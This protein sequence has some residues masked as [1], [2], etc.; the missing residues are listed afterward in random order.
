MITWE[1]GEDRILTLTLDDRTQQTNT[2]NERFAADLGATV[3]R[4]EAEKDSFDGVILTSAKESFVAGGDLVLLMESGPEDVKKIADGLDHYKDCFRRIER[5]GRPV[6]AAVNGTALGGGFE[7]ALAAH[8]RI[9]LD[10]P[11]TL[12]GLPEVT[13]GVLPGAGGVTRVVRMIGVVNAMLQVIGQGQRMKPQ[14]AL[15]VGIVDEVVSTSEEMFAHARAWIQANPDASQPW[16]KPGYRI[17]GGSA[18]SSALAANL[19][20]FPANLRKQLKGAPMPA[21]AAVLATAVEGAAVDVDSAFRI[22]TRYCAN[23]ICGPVSGNMIKALFFDMNKVNKGTSR[24][25]GYPERRPEK[26]AVLGAGMMGAAIAYVTARAGV[27]VVLKDVSLE[28]AERGKDYSRRLLD[29]AVAKGRLSEQLREEVLGRIVATDNVAELKGSDFVVEAVFEDLE[30]KKSVLAEVE[31]YLS[32]DALIAT[33]TSALPL[34]EMAAAV[35]RPEDFIGLHFFSPVDKMPLLEVVVA[36]GTSAES[37]ARAFDFARII[38]KTPIVVRDAYAFYANRVI[39]QFVDQALSMLGEGVHPASIEQATTQAGF[40]VGALALL[41]EVNMRTTIKI[42]E[43]MMADQGES[44]VTTP[45][46]SIQRR[47]VEE[48]DRPGRA[49]GR[50]FYDYA[51]DGARLGLWPQLVDEYHRSEVVIP[52]DDL[53]ERLLVAASLEAARCLESGIIGT[54]EE[55]NVGSILGIGFPAWTGGALQYINQYDG[56]PAGFVAR[57][58]ALRATYGDRFTV[59]AS[60]RDR[61]ASDQPYC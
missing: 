25:A 38:N 8:R 54:V 27:T 48:F 31:P 35:S 11:G 46:T 20:A 60:L 55:A 39:G 45:G 5:L 26:V 41:D 19:P 28:A 43:G 13:L 24:P 52:F 2:M 59:P 47:M 51:D 12:V 53:K 4:L 14:Q 18:S 17:P 57:A 40:P 49:A 3:A 37:L 32:D 22:E 34:G 36:D 33:N 58:D 6:V 61:A 9:V 10:A 16:D 15:Q 30:L 50:G 21:P 1:V 23:L 44:Y 7:V 42:Q 29:A 56:G